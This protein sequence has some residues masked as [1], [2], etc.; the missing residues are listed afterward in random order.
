LRK[1]FI[2]TVGVAG[3]TLG[4]GL[5][6]LTGKH[7]LSMDN[8]VAA[9]IVLA[10][11]SVE[12]ISST[13]NPDLFWAIRGCGYNFGVVYELVIKAHDHPN[14]VYAGML[15][16]PKEKYK[17]VYEKV[18]DLDLA[19]HDDVLCDVVFT[20][21]P[22]EFQP[23]VLVLLFL[24]SPSAEE[25]RSRFSVLYDMQPIQDTSRAVSYVESNRLY[26]HLFVYGDRKLNIAA[27]SNTPFT[28]SSVESA[29]Q[30]FLDF[31][32]PTKELGKIFV[33]SS[34]Q[35]DF[36][37]S[38]GLKK[39]KNDE[40]VYPSRGK[41]VYTALVFAK[42]LDDKYDKEAIKWLNQT[43]ELFEDKTK[44]PVKLI[45][46]SN[47]SEEELEKHFNPEIVYGKENL[48]KLKVIKRKYDPTCFFNKWVPI[49][50]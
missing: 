36:H 26:N 43:E 35:F 13:S 21:I 12:Q 32:D 2:D 25:F 5:G 14:D 41:P 29:W 24:D 31:T 28:T 3:Y 20:R 42:W 50:I 38:E 44:N 45:S 8:L 27:H 46:C 11:G 7:G 33:Q 39:V 49:K 40:T 15:A 17:E 47:P 18:K 34:V 19:K 16:F 22:P 23:T 37:S 9:T 10:D 6:F 1:R 30:S 4:G 48:E